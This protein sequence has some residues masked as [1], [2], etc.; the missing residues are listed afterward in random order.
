MNIK[1]EIVKEGGIG[2]QIDSREE[3]VLAFVKSCRDTADDYR[4][5]FKDKW[6]TILEQIAQQHPSEWSKKLA[7]QTRIFIGIQGKKSETASAYIH[8]MLFGNRRF[9]NVEGV[10]GVDKMIAESVMEY[11]DNSFERGE[12][13]YQNGFVLQEATDIGTSFMKVLVNPKMTGVDFI[14]R[15]P[16]NVTFDPTCGGDFYKAKYVCDEYNKKLQDIVDDA[17][18]G[19]GIYKWDKIKPLLEKLQEEGQG[20]TNKSTE[21]MLV[22]KGIDDTSYI[23]PQEYAEVSLVEFWGLVPVVNEQDLNGVKQ[24]VVLYEQRIV[25]MANEKYILRDDV[26]EYGFIPYFI[27]PV[28][29]R[30]YDAY[31]KGFCYN[32]ID[33]QKLMN[34]MINLGFDSLKMC[35]MDIAMI[36]ADKVKD[37]ASIEYR[38]MAIWKFKDN[39]NLCVSLTR[40]GLSALKD[41]LGGINTLDMIDQE[42]SG[43]LRQIQG[44]QQLSGGNET[45]GEYQAKLAMIDNRFLYI[46]RQIERAYVEHLIKGVFRILFNKKFF[47]QDSVNRVLGFKKVKQIDPMTG[48]P[49]EV[50][51]PRLDFDLIAT[52]GELGFD[53]KAT[54]MTQY[55]SKMEQAQKLEKVMM[56]VLRSP[57]LKMITKVDE[58]WKRALQTAE[59]PDYEDL[60]KSDAEIQGAMGQLGMPQEAMPIPEGLAPNPAI[61]APQGGMGPQAG[62]SLPP[63]PPEILMALQAGQV[64]QGV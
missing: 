54:G 63:V 37:P 53:F 24:K 31:G 41:V 49:V 18:S 7:W 27:C 13:G 38:P 51:A 10:E 15:S 1:P 59:I 4:K 29:I 16:Y 28:K 40:Q 8:K 20:K 17:I 39:P 30:L 52:A 47:N 9:Y 42:Q 11:M 56:A 33:T 64:P 32:S 57:D 58:L 48:Q 12:F 19:R 21:A 26:N 34:S 5:R 3:K 2:P 46:A 60:L 25:T 45:L 50:D 55:T 35:S 43:V 36:N 22:V 61:Q 62:G 44:S 23:V 14:W 6:D